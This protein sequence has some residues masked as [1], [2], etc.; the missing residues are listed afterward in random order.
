M[1]RLVG[2]LVFFCAVLSLAEWGVPSY[3]P[4]RHHNIERLYEFVGLLTSA[5]V[6]W[7]GIARHWN[8]VVNTSATAFVIF[9]FTRLY[10]WWWDWMPKYLFFAVIGA[11]GIALV[12]AFR[13]LR[14]QMAMA[15][16]GMKRTSL[17]A[18]AAIVLIANTF[19]LV[20]AAR[21]RSGSPESDVTLTQREL[22]EF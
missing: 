10:H 12:M 14:G 20:H 7:L 11:L 5:G 1:Y 8:G 15:S 22:A 9:L 19:A 13:R 21:N 16:S 2:T 17:L 4:F 3:L 6:I 18:A